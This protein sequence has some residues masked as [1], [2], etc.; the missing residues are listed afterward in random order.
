MYFLISKK[1]VFT[2]LCNSFKLSRIIFPE[3]VSP[4]TCSLAEYRAE[5]IV[6]PSSILTC[7]NVRSLCVPPCPL[8]DPVAFL[9]YL[10]RSA[11]FLLHSLLHF[12][13]F[14]CGFAHAFKLSVT[15]YRQN[16]KVITFE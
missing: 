16:S 15:F 12:P 3:E 8:G 11:M 5:K 4:S 9:G 10:V 14:L 6:V 1:S 13:W 2:A 7:W